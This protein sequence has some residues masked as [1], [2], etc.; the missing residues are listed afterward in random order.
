MTVERTDIEGE[1]TDDQKEAREREEARDAELAQARKETEDAKLAAA[2]AEG[3]A[4]AMRRGI[5]TEVPA[6]AE[7]SESQ[8]TQMESES[9]L[10]RQQIQANAK[11]TG[12]LMQS[13]T[14]PLAERAE[15]AEKAANE[16]R[17]ET[18]KLRSGK[19]LEKAEKEF[20]EK[21]PG[22]SAH[23]GDIEEFMSDYP[24]AIKEDPKKYAV[25]LEKA[26]TFVRGKAREDLSLRRTGKT[27]ASTNT[28]RTEFDER[29]GGTTSD[30]NE[31]DTSDLDNEGA[32]SLVAR[33]HKNP[34]PD[35][36]RADQTPLSELPIEEAFK[37]SERPDKRG[38]S[39][40]ESAEWSRGEQRANR[41]LRDTA[42]L[43]GKRGK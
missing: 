23:R 1:E 26:K 9:G 10:T 27:S 13:L 15:A 42:N 14:K 12:A 17:E 38:V 11:L 28:E 30:D 33:L 35:Y 25:L 18:R 37:K 40:D 36:L 34:G 24:D 43:G 32:K 41:A 2:R 39:I 20:Y 8:W 16:A 5:K 3:E 29:V 4:E 6:P 7:I 22:L 31:L 21:N 19:T